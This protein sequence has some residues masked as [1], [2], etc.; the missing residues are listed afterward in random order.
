MRRR[1][2]VLSLVMLVLGNFVLTAAR[3]SVERPSFKG[4]VFHSTSLARLTVVLDPTG[5]RLDALSTSSAVALSKQ[6]GPI[7]ARDTA[8]RSIATFRGQVLVTD[9]DQTDRNTVLVTVRSFVHLNGRLE[10]R[11]HTTARLAHSGSGWT[12]SKQR[13]DGSWTPAIQSGAPEA[14]AGDLICEAVGGVILSVVCGAITKNEAI[15]AACTG[16]GAAG[17]REVCDA[18]GSGSGKYLQSCVTE[19][20]HQLAYTQ[21]QYSWDF[22]STIYNEPVESFNLG[23]GST[24]WN[25]WNAQTLHNDYS[26]GVFGYTGQ[27]NGW[28]D[29]FYADGHITDPYFINTIEPNMPDGGEYV[30][31]LSSI[32]ARNGTPYGASYGPFMYTKNV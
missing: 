26:F 20:P 2:A 24:I 15:T 6:V 13:A 27:D 16:A 22:V 3:G 9:L 21:G 5:R 12:L 11:E 23:S 19:Y 25:W 29:V 14:S 8:M 32:S 30:C 7:P 17:G 31:V 10:V 28:T 1:V 4:L 18:V